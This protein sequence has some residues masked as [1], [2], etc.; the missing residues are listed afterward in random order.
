MGGR[1]EWMDGRR[2]GRTEGGRDREREGR[3]GSFWLSAKVQS[4][5][6]GKG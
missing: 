1:E 5:Q 3:V 6:A 4:T 2:E